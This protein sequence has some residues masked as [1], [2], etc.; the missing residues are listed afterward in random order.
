MN[1]KIN[2]AKN[3]I[4]LSALESHHKFGGFSTLCLCTGAGKSRCG[5]LRA[6]EVVDKN[7]NARIL[8]ACFTTD[9]RDNVWRLEFDEWGE[10]DI[11]KNNVVE[12][13]CYKSL[14]TISNQ[15]FDLCIFDE[16][17]HITES[18]IGFFETNE[19]K[20]ILGLTATPP[21]DK[22]KAA[23]INAV[24]PISFV[25][26]MEQGIKDGVVASYQ[27]DIIYLELEDKLKTVPAGSKA[28]P[29]KQTEKSAYEYWDKV[30]T[31]RGEEMREFIS[32]NLWPLGWSE[33]E[34]YYNE[35]LVERNRDQVDKYLK[36]LG[37]IKSRYMAAMQKRT[38]II[39][40]SF[41][42]TRV[43]KRL[44]NE[45]CKPENRYLFFAGSIAQSNELLP[46]HT[47]NS[48]SGMDA[49]NA[50]MNEEENILIAVDGVNEGTNIRN[51]DYGIVMQLNSK[52]LG[53]IQRIGRVTRKRDNH[54]GKI[55]VLCLK[56]T[57]DVVWLQ[58]ALRNMKFVPIKEYT[59]EEF[60]ESIKQ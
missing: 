5:I 54:I 3:K 31:E 11:Y 44:L 42:K 50:F 28:K 51:L 56:N 57:R 59:E 53:I 18:H 35:K 24:A 4:Q 14:H 38:Q 33:D 9:Q 55:I 36:K 13:V 22:N 10:S 34:R 46:T 8:L 7:P 40:N 19:I 37:F 39:K 21:E 30:F 60:F 26:K 45:F 29:F 49:Y 52:E 1:N 17:H 58:K 48:E 43:A 6:R 20:S 25:Y 27:I 23:I 16:F 12:K 41:N 47:Y 2:E 32:Q 15:K